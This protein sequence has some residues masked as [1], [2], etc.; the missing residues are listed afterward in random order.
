MQT[1]R[2]M[3]HAMQNIKE[4]PVFFEFSLCLSRACLGKMI[5]FQYKWRKNWLFFPCRANSPR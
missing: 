4:M 2:R 1:G 5:H 3:Q